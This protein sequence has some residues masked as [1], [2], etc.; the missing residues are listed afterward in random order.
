MW[1]ALTRKIASDV[2]AMSVADAKAHLR[3]DYSDDDVMIEALI[4][5]AQA[6]IEGPEGRGLAL[7]TQ[8]W[9]M[10]LDSWYGYR[11]ETWWTQAKVYDQVVRSPVKI[12][13]FPV[14]SVT[15][16]Q[17]VAPDGTTQ[18]LDPSEYRADVSRQPARLVPEFGHV[19]PVH[20]FVPSPIAIEF[21][22]GFGDTA[23]K[24]PRD[25]VQALKLLLKHYYDNRDAVLV[26]SRENRGAI[27]LPWG[28]ESIVAR[29]APVSVG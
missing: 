2:P 19:W 16:I 23:D 13:L 29:Y 25:L 1:N 24:V 5:A 3:V 11:Y 26:T 9:V 7:T 4:A 8:S 21:K 17:F 20:R 22:A 18:T 12:P 14:Q 15:S 6:A 27:E 28:V 10:T